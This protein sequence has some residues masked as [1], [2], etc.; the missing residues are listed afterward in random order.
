MLLRQASQLAAAGGKPRGGAHHRPK[1][2]I[3]PHILDGIFSIFFK[4]ISNVGVYEHIS[5]SQAVNGEGLAARYDLLKAIITAAPSG[6]IPPGPARASLVKVFSQRPEANTTVFNTGVFAGLRLDRLTVMLAHLRRC[7]QD[8]SR[9]Q[10][11]AVKMTGPS[12]AKV[13]ELVSMVDKEWATIEDANSTVTLYY[14]P[15]QC[16]PPQRINQM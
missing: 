11:A 3:D 8:P 9:M 4:D 7:A 14:D 1:P 15:A 16:T 6:G 2:P 12:L 5:K 13:Q 10:Q